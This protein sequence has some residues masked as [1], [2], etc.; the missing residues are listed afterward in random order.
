MAHDLKTGVDDAAHAAV[1]VVGQAWHAAQSATSAVAHTVTRYASEGYHAVVHVVHTAVHDVAKAATATAN[2]VK[3]HAAA[4]A[5]VVVSVAVFAG[6]DAA[7]GIATGGIGAVAGAAAC[8]ALAGAAGNAVSYGIT[9]AQ[10]GKFS[11]SGFGESVLKGAATGALAG[12]L[13]AGLAEGASALGDAASGLLDSGSAVDSAEEATSAAAGDAA[14]DGAAASTDGGTAGVEDAKAADASPGGNAAEEESNLCTVGGQSFSAGTKVLTGSG[15]LVA[16]SK[17]KVGEKIRATNVKTGKT[18]NE[19]VSAV[20]VHHDTNR[21]DLRVKT[22]HGTGVI[23]TTRNHLFFDVT[24]RSWVKAGALKYGTHLRTAGGGTATA[25][26]GYDPKDTTGWMWDLTVPDDHDFY[27]T[28]G[29]SAVLVHNCDLRTIS[30]DQS[31]AQN[32]TAI[33]IQPEGNGFSGV[34]DPAT[35]NFEARLSSEPNNLVS[36]F[37]GHGVINGEVFGG[38]ESTV[39]FTAIV[40]DEGLEVRWNSASVNLANWGTRAAPEGFREGILSALREA[41]GMSAQG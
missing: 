20:L 11:W 27:V 9:A 6:C 35:S 18:T 17:L 33:R 21:Y 38:S 10:T 8:G 39:G 4:I 1:H 16:I 5:S 22:A 19:T 15:A 28:A 32:R 29:G 2:F 14:G 31:V 41:T 30:S 23:D 26:G 40:R 36:Q 7:L 12:G 37:G 13:G 25:T 34:Y 24:T 3:N